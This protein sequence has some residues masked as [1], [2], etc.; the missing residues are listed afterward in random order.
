M[1]QSTGSSPL[2]DIEQALARMGECPGFA[3][4]VIAS[5]DGL[6][7]ACSGDL[8]GD[9]AAA[10]AAS[11]ALDSSSA[12]SSVGGKKAKELMVWADDQVWFQTCL[13][14]TTHLLLAASNDP[15]HSGA[16]RVTVHRELTALAAALSKL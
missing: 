16:L 3:G 12:L 15:L 9:A 4:V 13:P 14:T 6:V 2:R 11:L 10:C 5:A 7:L 8:V 1:T